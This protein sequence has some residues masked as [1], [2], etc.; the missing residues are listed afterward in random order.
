MYLLWN[1]RHPLELTV[2]S[3][4]NGEDG[5]ATWRLDRPNHTEDRSQGLY[6]MPSSPGENQ[7]TASERYS[8]S[9]ES[10]VDWA[11]WTIRFITITYLTTVAYHLWSDETVRAYALHVTTH[12]LQ[13]LARLIGGLAISTENNYNSLVSTW[14]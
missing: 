3:I 4:T 8:D 5:N 10:Q 1:T 6:P 11:A 2:L 14:H 13:S 9:E 7:P 12:F